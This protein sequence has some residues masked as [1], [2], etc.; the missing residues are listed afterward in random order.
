MSIKVTSGVFE[1][2]SGANWTPGQ[3][4]VL[5]AL[6]DHADDEGIC[7]PG[8]KRV[9]EKCG[10]ARET[11]IRYIK[12]LGDDG[13]LKAEKRRGQDGRQMTTV[14]HFTAQFL[15]GPQDETGGVT[16]QEPGDICAG[17]RVTSLPLLGDIDDAHIYNTTI[18]ESPEQQ[19]PHGATALF[20][21]WIAIWN[22]VPHVQKLRNIEP[23]YHS[24]EPL[25]GKIRA[26]LKKKGWLADAVVAMEK[27]KRG[28][29]IAFEDFTNKPPSFSFIFQST[30]IPKIVAGEYDRRWV[31]WDAPK[32]SSLNT[33]IAKENKRVED[34]AIA[35]AKKD[36]LCEE[37]E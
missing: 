33:A 8:M 10:L 9:A 4:L 18:S 12:K 3:R 16:I 20:R 35:Q 25:V 36:G 22:S 7:W 21:A 31:D 17:D 29:C 30:G 28:D 1:W 11:V 24:N 19:P 37:G 23:D 26:G 32:M 2:G 13:W 6:A 5:L 15:N 34:A 27:L 14:Y